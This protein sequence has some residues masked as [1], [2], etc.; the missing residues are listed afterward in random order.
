MRTAAAFVQNPLISAYPDT[1]YRTGDL[2]AYNDR[3]ELLY[4]GRK[5]HQI[6][7]LGYR[8]ELGEIETVMNG[9]EGAWRIGP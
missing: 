8:I 1:V 5:D 6:K 3:G 7:H 4:F 2:V 9:V